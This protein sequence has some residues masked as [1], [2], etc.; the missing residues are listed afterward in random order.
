[1]KKYGLD[2]P[3]APVTIGIGQ[4]ARRAGARRQGGQGRRVRARPEQDHGGHR[5]ARPA[6]R[7]AEG[8][9]RL[10]P[11]G[12]LR[13]PRLQPDT[14][15]AHARHDDARCREGQGEGKD[16]ADTWQN[17]RTKKALDA[18]KFDAFLTKLAGFRAQSFADPKAKTGL[19]QPVLSVKATYD[20]GKKT[21][22]VN[23]GRV[24]SDVFAGRPDE[25]GAAKLDTGEF[26]GALKDLAA[27]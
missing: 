15:R 10:S 8:R 17:L 5:G 19:D 14:H 12:H 2:K 11:Q 18:A 9:Q 3:A 13:V 23:I 25:P 7:T 27:F 6:D 1:M 26:E 16:A 22:S 21:E 24:G 4:R 20:D